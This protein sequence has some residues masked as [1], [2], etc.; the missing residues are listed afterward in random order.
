MEGFKYRDE[1]IGLYVVV[2][3]LGEDGVERPYLGQVREMHLK[4]NDDD[5]GLEM[6][7][8]VK[9][10]EDGDECWLDLEDLDNEN[11]LKIFDI[12]EQRSQR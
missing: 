4:M 10:A 9:F 6:L 2:Q 5:D 12:I 3:F 8:C 11:I 1:V 7:H